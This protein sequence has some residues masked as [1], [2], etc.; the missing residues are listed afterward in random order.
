MTGTITT[1]QRMSIGDGPGIRSTVLM[2]GCRFR[3]AWCHNPETWTS[4]PL[5]QHIPGRCIACHSCLKACK[6]HALTF[7]GE[8]TVLDRDLCDSCGSC[9]AVCPSGALSMTGRTVEAEDVFKEVSLDLPFYIESG[10]G[11]TLSGGEPLLQHEF[12]VELL[13]LCKGAGIDTAI[14]TTLDTEWPRLEVL[15][16]LVDLW[17]VDLKTQDDSLHIKY[18]GASNE[19]TL[20]NLGLLSS[21]AKDIIVRTPVVPGVNDNPESIEAICSFL[22]S[23]GV[24]R[25]ELLPFHDL[26]FD[27]YTGYGIKNRMAGTRSLSRND[28]M[29]LE[30]IVAGHGFNGAEHGL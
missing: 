24:T 23:I 29:Q 27:K 8:K 3:C 25:Y 11:V 22:D 2:K 5:L 26:G 1:I 16:P 19:T 15:A 4:S 6:S 28:L 7:D 10:G 14:E 9:A 30:E 17:M 13:S 12:I 18:T 20:K 21:R